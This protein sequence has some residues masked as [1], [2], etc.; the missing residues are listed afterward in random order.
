MT[1]LFSITTSAA[2]TTRKTPG[3]AL[4]KHYQDMRL[5]SQYQASNSKEPLEKQRIQ[6]IDF[7]GFSLYN[8]EKQMSKYQIIWLNEKDGRQGRYAI[9]YP[10][11]K[12]LEEDLTEEEVIQR[13]SVQTGIDQA[14]LVKFTICQLQSGAQ[15][16]RNPISIERARILSMPKER[17]VGA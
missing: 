1:A 4:S 12:T 8:T 7:F 9:W 13:L 17:I 3:C 10:N 15:P 6:L 2:E 11:T 16:Y 5:Q 14:G